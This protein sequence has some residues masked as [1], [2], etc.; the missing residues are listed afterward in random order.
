MSYLYDHP[1]KQGRCRKAVSNGSRSFSWHQCYRKVVKG[2]WCTIHHPSAVEARRAASRDKWEKE[3]EAR[4]NLPVERALR[5]ATVAQL[6]A[7]LGRRSDA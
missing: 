1:P 6:N 3:L 5:R 2:E 7:E 4:H